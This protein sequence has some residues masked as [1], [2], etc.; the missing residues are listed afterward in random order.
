MIK[1]RMTNR[2]L[3]QHLQGIRTKWQL[4]I[5]NF[6]QKKEGFLVKKI[7]MILIKI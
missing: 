4:K 3:S 2:N 7:R 1:I 6:L 5:K